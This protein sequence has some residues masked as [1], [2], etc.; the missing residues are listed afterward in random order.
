[1]FNDLIPFEGIEE[2]CADLAGALGALD[3]D[4]AHL[5]DH[6]AMGAP[7][8]TQSVVDTIRQRFRRHDHPQRRLRRRAHRGRSR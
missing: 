1:M 6:S 8:P 2:Q 3:T 4:Y 7:A 5:V